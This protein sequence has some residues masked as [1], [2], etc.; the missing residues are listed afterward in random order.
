MTALNAR[1]EPSLSVAGVSIRGVI[2]READSTKAI[3]I[4]VPAA[5][6]GTLTTR[7]TD[8]TG[9]I[10]LAADHGVTTG[11]TVDLYW[12]GGLRYG[13]TVGTVSGTAVPISG[14][15]G[16][17]LPAQD[18][19][20][21]VGPTVLADF[22]VTGDNIVIM[23]MQAVAAAALTTH[24][25]HI[26]FQDSVG[27]EVQVELATNVPRVIDV[28]GGDTNILAADSIINVL[29][30]TNYTGGLQLRVGAL[31]DATP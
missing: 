23:G 10:T 5:K 16:T 17:V 28:E 7:S 1:Y 2:N 13:V 22:V 18:T 3:D 20:V 9:T 6:E 30:S 8:T 4:A 25:C 15:A 26:D 27:S 21:T 14:G 19:A 12:A 11:A 31:I 24:R 29:V